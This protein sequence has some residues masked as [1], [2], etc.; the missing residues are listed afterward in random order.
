[1]SLREKANDYLYKAAQ[2]YDAPKHCRVCCP[3]A[4]GGHSGVLGTHS[5]ATLRLAV[6]SPDLMWESWQLLTDFWQFTVQNLD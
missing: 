4:S 3:Y 2:I 6:Q 5:P 1:M